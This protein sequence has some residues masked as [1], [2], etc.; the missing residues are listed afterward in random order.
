MP[1]PFSSSIRMIEETPFNFCGLTEQFTAFEKSAIVLLPVLFDETTTWLK[2]SDRGPDAI[3]E[4]SRNLEL[5]DIE[6]DSEVYRNGIHTGHPIRATGSEAM[7]VKVEAKTSELIRLG[8][9]VVT[10]GGE[11]SVSIGAIRAHAAFYKGMAVLHLDAHTDMRDEYEGN[12][13]SHACTVARIKE[14][15]QT[16]VSVGIRSMDSS[17]R[18]KIDEKMVFYAARIHES[19]D[20]I[21]ETVALLPGQVYITIDLDVFDPG[22]MPSI[23]TPEP[24]GMDW[25][26]VIRLLKAVSDNRMITG[27]DVV[28]L[29]PTDNKTPDFMAA[30]LIYK[31]LSYRFPSQKM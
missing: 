31:L 30:K 25:Y 18:E 22:I 16:V 28:E 6:T 12:R 3:I 19:D 15:V 20:W 1:Q 23:G 2:G 4:A 5:Y 21:T 11:H 13:Y 24:G 26:Q 8:K 7:I 9:F 14:S 10:L 29:C 17:E 27:F